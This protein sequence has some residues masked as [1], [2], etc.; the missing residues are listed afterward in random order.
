MIFL[1]DENFPANG[2]ASVERLVKSRHQFLRAGPDYQKGISDLELFNVA[3]K[4]GAEAIVTADLRQIQGQ[5]RIHERDACRKAGLHWIGVPRNPR[6]SGRRTAHGQAAQF[7]LALEPLVQ[8]MASAPCP[9]AF[10]L[11]PGSERVPYVQGFPQ[12]L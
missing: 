10:L 7:I 2:L 5:D 3:S 6:V 4:L 9:Q 11:R 1:V 8:E 12:A